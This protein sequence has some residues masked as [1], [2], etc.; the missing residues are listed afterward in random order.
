M[1]TTESKVT[2]APKGLP[3]LR[4]PKGLLD[5]PETKASLAEDLG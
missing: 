4:A 2:L 3:V 5:P 1:G